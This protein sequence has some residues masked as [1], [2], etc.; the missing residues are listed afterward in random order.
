MEPKTLFLILGL[1][2]LVLSG[3]LLA[4]YIIFTRYPHLTGKTGSTLVSTKHRDKETV[5][6]QLGSRF[7]VRDITTGFYTYKVGDR[8]YKKKNKQYFTKPKQMPYSIPIVYLKRFPRISYV[9]DSGI[10][11]LAYL[12]PAIIFGAG[13]ILLVASLLS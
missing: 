7:T 6:G 13:A 2:I 9:N 10:G 3:A 11:A 5:F 12:I 8:T 4:V 1:L